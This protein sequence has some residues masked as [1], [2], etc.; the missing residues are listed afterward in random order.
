MGEGE[1][2][3]AGSSNS[4]FDE[5][6]FPPG[7]VHA[8]MTPFLHAREVIHEPGALTLALFRDIGWDTGPAL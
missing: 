4:H 1:Q 7:T 6:A 8:L 3:G 2:R 5:N